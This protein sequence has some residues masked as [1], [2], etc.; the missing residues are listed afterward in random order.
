MH[1]IIG[2]LM[3]AISA[4]DANRSFSSLLREVA[5]GQSFVVTSRGKPVARIVPL[6]T[7]A[8]GRTRARRVL[9]DRLKAQLP[10]GQPRTWTRDDLYE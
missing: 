5:A 3:K 8:D 2:R 7:G 1:Y 4:S 6:R 9:L 10:S